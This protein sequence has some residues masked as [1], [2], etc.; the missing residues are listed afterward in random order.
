[1]VKQGPALHLDL[2]NKAECGFE[3][4]QVPADRAS[5]I[6]DNGQALPQSLNSVGMNI[7][8]TLRIKNKMFNRNALYLFYVGITIKYKFIN[9]IITY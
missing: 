1:M 9:Y 6:L 3:L 5:R 8:R 4:K 2:D 7:T